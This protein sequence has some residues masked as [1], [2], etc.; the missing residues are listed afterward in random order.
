MGISSDW[1]VG[2][3]KV[4]NMNPGFTDVEQ[5][6]ELLAAEELGRSLGPE[7]TT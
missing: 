3:G 2:R 5:L 4:V 7:K 1:W 6:S